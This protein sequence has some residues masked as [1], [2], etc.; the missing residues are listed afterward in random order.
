MNHSFSHLANPL[1]VEFGRKRK[2]LFFNS[3]DEF[4]R[5]SIYSVELIGDEFEADCSTLTLEQEWG[6]KDSYFSHGISIG[7]SFTFDG[8]TFISI[9]GWKVPSGEHWRGEI[10]LLRLDGNAHVSQVTDTPWLGLNDEDPISKSYPAVLIESG[11]IYIWYGTTI[12]WDAGNG[13]ML[14]VIKEARLDN[15][16]GN[17]E[18]LRTLPYL[19]GKAQAFAR[20]AVTLVD[21]RKLMAYSYRG[22]SMGYRIG[23][24][25]L[26]DLNTAS[27]LGGIPAFGP[28]T[29]DWEDE[30]VEYPSFFSHNDRKFMLYNGNGFGR[31]GLG[32]AEIEIIRT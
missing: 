6:P 16:W 12:S 3:R 24:V 31:T 13:E 5:S 4:Q 19:I 23:F 22:S 2:R 20:P 25:W 9:M 10:G 32:L 15:L 18:Q 27:H 11:G 26:D 8:D 30:M 29:A 14:H 28:S 17:S 21:Q 7:S 1:I